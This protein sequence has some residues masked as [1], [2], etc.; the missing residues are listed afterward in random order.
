V[1]VETSGEP[2]GEGQEMEEEIEKEWQ[3]QM[4]E[5]EAQPDHDWWKQIAKG[6]LKNFP[7]SVQDLFQESNRIEEPSYG[8][9]SLEPVLEP[10]SQELNRLVEPES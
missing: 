2:N 3:F 7:Q 10:I 6:L 1:K 8:S 5:E 9:N 4:L